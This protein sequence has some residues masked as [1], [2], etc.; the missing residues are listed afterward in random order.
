MKETK[1]LK[2]IQVYTIA[3][4]VNFHAIVC[5]DLHH[6]EIVQHDLS[7]PTCV[8]CSSLV[9]YN[10]VGYIPGYGDLFGPV[11]VPSASDAYVVRDERHLRRVSPAPE[12]RFFNEE[13]LRKT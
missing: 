5:A 8:Y 7:C 13:L 3:C 10:V 12:A 6:L 2:M 4:S 9:N 1:S 11:M